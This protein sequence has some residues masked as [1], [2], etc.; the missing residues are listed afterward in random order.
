MSYGSSVVRGSGP[1]YST[2]VGTHP[3]IREDAS[4]DI[5]KAAIQKSA[6]M[7]MFRHRNMGKQQQRMPVLAAKATAYFVS[8]DVGLKQ[9]TKIS[10]DNKFLD[11]EEIAVIVP[12]PEKLLDDADYNIWAEVKPELEE[13]IGVTLD[14]AVLFGFNKPSI[15]PSDLCT[16]AIAAGNT[17]TQG[18]G[19]DIADDINSMMAAVEIDGYEVNGFFIR[20]SMKGELRGLRDTN[21]AFIFQAP[22]TS[23]LSNTVYKGTIYSEKAVSG[24]SGLFEAEDAGTYGR[25]ANSVKAIAGDWNQGMLG[26]RQ[27]LTYKMLDQAVI[28]DDQGR[29]VW[30]LPQQDMVALRVVTRLAFQ[31]PNPYNRMATSASTR[32][33]FSVLRDAS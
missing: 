23:G 13:A 29:V 8:G 5:L 30:N 6:V 22:A 9:T 12:I 3:L 18:S 7:A 20:A 19:V 26:I 21:G 14:A 10:W 33:P 2:T 15:W 25:S 4:T 11:A 24:M 17:V 1:T 31:V 16:A 32:Y 27:D 28:N